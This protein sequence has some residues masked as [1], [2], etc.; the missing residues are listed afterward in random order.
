VRLGVVLNAPVV[1]PIQVV[2]PAPDRVHLDAVAGRPRP[3]APRRVPGPLRERSVGET[4]SD[5]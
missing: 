5:D 4:K 1:P 3:P 2:A